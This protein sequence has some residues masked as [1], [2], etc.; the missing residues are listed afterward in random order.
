MKENRL[1]KK[2]SN[3]NLYHEEKDEDRSEWL[4]GSFSVKVNILVPSRHRLLPCFYVTNWMIPLLFLVSYIPLPVLR[5]NSSVHEVINLDVRHDLVRMSFTIAT[6]FLYLHAYCP[7]SVCSNICSRRLPDWKKWF[8]I[9]M[10]SLSCCNLLWFSILEL[11]C[12]NIIQPK[13]FY[14]PQLSRQKKNFFIK[15]PEIRYNQK[16]T[17]SIR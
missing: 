17:L 15:D 16:T 14:S 4:W 1:L 5:P 13:Y 12:C 11:P 9:P 3:G 6:I 10:T 7:Y 8:N 2:D